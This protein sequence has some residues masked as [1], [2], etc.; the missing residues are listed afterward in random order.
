MHIGDA[1][2]GDELLLA[3]EHV[4]VAVADSGGL[5]VGHVGAGVW[6]GEAHRA[7]VNLVRVGGDARQPL[8]SL[9]GR[10]RRRDGGRG[11]AGRIDREGYAGAAPRELFGHDRRQ[12]RRSAALE[13][14]SLAGDAETDG[15]GLLDDVVGDLFVFVVVGGDGPDLFLCEVVRDLLN[16]LLFVRKFETDHA[17]ALL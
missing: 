13:H 2:V 14:A 3:V 17:S 7:E 11:K 15:S 5:D 9:L 16:K 6:L 10:A 1:A 4:L 12:E 8:L